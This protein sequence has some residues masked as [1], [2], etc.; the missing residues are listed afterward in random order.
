MSIVIYHNP[1]CQKSRAALHLLQ[2]NNC[3]FEVVEYLKQNP[4]ANE[5][6][7]LLAKLKLKA[8]DLIRTKE[9]AFAPY[10]NQSLTNTQYINLM[11]EFPV[12]IE[13]PIVIK[14]NKAIIGRPIEKILELI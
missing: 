4:T 10:K 3:E 7:K 6:K 8:I 13:R 2:E 14:G 1:R 5:I 9:P 12:L 11:V